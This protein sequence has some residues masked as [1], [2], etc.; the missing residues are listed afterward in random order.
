MLFITFPAQLFN[1]TLE[2]NYDDIRDIAVRRFHAIAEARRRI[3]RESSPGTRLLAFSAVVLIGG[4]LGSLNDPSFGFNRSSGITYLGVLVSALF[5]VLVSTSIARTYRHA[6]K[7]DE[8]GRL[9]ALPAGLLV[10]AACVLVSR[11]TQFR[12]GYLYG[13]I[14]GVAFTKKL[15]KD[16]EGQSI[17]AGTGVSFAM[18]LVAWFAWVPVSGGADPSV[19]TVLLTDFLAS[20]AVGGLVGCALGLMPIKFLPGGALMEWNRWIWG[21]AFG[22]AL[23]TLVQALLHPDASPAQP[24]N[25]PIITAA[26]LLVVFGAGSVAFNRYFE[27]RKKRRKEEEGAKAEHPVAGSPAEA[28]VSAAVPVEGE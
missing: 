7:K 9:H 5:G 18:A 27:E 14:A 15:T 19:G 22:L 17:V 3:V 12:P 4:L 23:F 2:E 28:S 26:V 8:R 16:E 21:S 10:A 24:G 20:L 11:I 13:V 1:K 6:R 25:A